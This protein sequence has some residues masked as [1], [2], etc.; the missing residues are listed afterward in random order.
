[1]VPTNGPRE[2]EEINGH[3]KVLIVLINYEG[4][5]SILFGCNDVNEINMAV[6]HKIKISSY[7]ALCRKGIPSDEGVGI[8]D[9][10]FMSEPHSNILD[11]DSDF[12]EDLE[13]RW[14]KAGVIAKALVM[15]G[16]AWRSP[17]MSECRMYEMVLTGTLQYITYLWWLAFI[18]YTER[19]AD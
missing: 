2:I 19:Q 13:E 3:Y 14:V 9:T 5:N 7:G 11:S 10:N 4:S 17:D 8:V 6:F 16:L 15:I 18:A 1:M 12:G